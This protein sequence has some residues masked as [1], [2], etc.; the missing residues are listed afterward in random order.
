VPSAALTPEL[1][2]RRLQEL[3]GEVRVAVLLDA[4]GELAAWRGPEPSR[5][6]GR[7]DGRRLAGSVNDLVRA[8]DRAQGDEPWTQVEVVTPLGGVFAVR[9]GGWTL[10]AACGRAALPSLMFLDLRSVLDELR[11]AVA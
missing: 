9:E 2:V 7:P 1:A 3:S 5:A 11:R 10:G 6:A 8:A 4:R